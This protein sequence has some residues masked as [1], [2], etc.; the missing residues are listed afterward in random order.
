M[1]NNS[2]N[3]KSNSFLKKIKALGLLF[4]IIL[5]TI[6]II[7]LLIFYLIE[8]IINLILTLITFTRFISIPLQIILHILLIRYIILEIAFSGQNLVISRS[9]YYSYGKIQA[10]HLYTLLLTFT[11]ALS[12]FNDIRGLAISSKE[13]NSLI[14][15]IDTINY[16]ING[17]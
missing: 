14:R 2:E 7:I 5:L 15:Q 3:E 4:I 6:I 9:L 11:G 17:C 1:Q 10:N 8:K 13:L 12:V 16:M